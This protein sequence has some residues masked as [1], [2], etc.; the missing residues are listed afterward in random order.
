MQ[1]CLLSHKFFT[2]HSL[3]L[4][5]IDLIS[6]ELELEPMQHLTSVVCA[7]GSCFAPALCN[8]LTFSELCFLTD[9]SIHLGHS[10]TH[11]S[12]SFSSFQSWS[13]ENSYYCCQRVWGLNAYIYILSLSFHASFPAWTVPVNFE[14]IHLNFCKVFP[15]FATLPLKKTHSE[16]PENFSKVLL[17]N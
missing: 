6:L 14:L 5:W 11:F 17:L 16:S 1:F 13:C 12:A 8:H 4:F 9:M 7:S 3:Q 10:Y 2:C 15:H